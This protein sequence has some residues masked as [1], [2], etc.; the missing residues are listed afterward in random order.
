MARSVNS[1]IGPGGQVARPHPPSAGTRRRQPRLTTQ[2]ALLYPY[3]GEWTESDYLAL[4]ETNRIV[5]LSEGR[6]VVPEM[7]TDPHQFAVGELFAA[8]RVFVR[9]RGLG[10]VRMAPLPVRLW[11]GKFREPDIIFL[12]REH[13]DRRGEQFWGVPDLVVEVISPRTE[14]SS[15]TERADRRD[16][17]EEYALS[18]IL[19]YWLVDPGRRTIEVFVLRD[20]VYHLLGKWGLEETARSELLKGF[21]VPV[22]AVVTE[23]E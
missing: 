9:D 1:E 18:G 22:A 19:E 21:E 20:G 23:E 16:K 7:P 11:P 15:G 12:S 2:V 17:F 13:G 14:H 6:L 8:L 5:E 4:P 3:Q 10:H